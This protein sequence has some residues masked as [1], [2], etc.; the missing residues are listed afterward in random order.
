ME[1]PE[2]GTQAPHSSFRSL[3]YLVFLGKTMSRQTGKLQAGQL[4]RSLPKMQ[5]RKLEEDSSLFNFLFCLAS[6][7]LP[8][9]HHSESSLPWALTQ[10]EPGFPSQMWETPPSPQTLWCAGHTGKALAS[11][12]QQRHLKAGAQ[13]GSQISRP[14][15]KHGEQERL[16]VGGWSLILLLQTRVRTQPET[17]L[18]RD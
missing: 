3:F 14:S 7:V 18:G 11:L 8:L 2:G 1:Y 4:C 12:G 15:W 6:S 13:L 5:R 17:K 16:G 9:P 10:E